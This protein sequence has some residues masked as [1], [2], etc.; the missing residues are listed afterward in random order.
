MPRELERERPHQVEAVE[1]ENLRQL[2]WRVAVGVEDGHRCLERL[3]RA[4]AGR[5]GSRRWLTWRDAVGVEDA[6]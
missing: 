4:Q 6:D 5:Y 2:T 3:R 1:C